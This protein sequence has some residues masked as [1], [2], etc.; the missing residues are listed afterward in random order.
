MTIM[1]SF[2]CG[3]LLTYSLMM[4]LYVQKYRLGQQQGKKQNRTE[5]NK[6]N[7]GMY[8]HINN[9]KSYIYNSADIGVDISTFDGFMEYFM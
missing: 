2:N 9:T 1:Y 5:Q 3:F 7:A 6:E 8:D 4:C